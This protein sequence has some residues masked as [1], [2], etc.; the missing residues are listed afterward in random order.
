M[1]ITAVVAPRPVDAGPTVVGARAFDAVD[2]LAAALGAATGTTVPVIEG[3]LADAPADGYLVVFDYQ[4]LAWFAALGGRIVLINADRASVLEDVERYGLAA[5]IEKHRYFQWRTRRQEETGRGVFGRKDVA[6]RLDGLHDTGYRE[7]A[8]Y[9]LLAS[10]RYPDLV[11]LLA[12]Y[13]AAHERVVQ[14]G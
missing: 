8:R 11:S 1:K 13:L 9:Q 4:D 5:A 7:T 10:S 6:A 12:A 3:T 2:E 14:G